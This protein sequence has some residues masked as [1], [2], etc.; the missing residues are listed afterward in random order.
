MKFLFKEVCAIAVI[1]IVLVYVLASQVLIVAGDSVGIDPPSTS[2]LRIL[3][4]EEEL[5]ITSAY[6]SIATGAVRTVTYPVMLTNAGEV[7]E[8][9]ALGATAPA[10]WYVCFLTPEGIP[11]ESLYLERGESRQ[12]VVRLAPSLDAGAGEISFVISA[13]SD[14]IARTSLNLTAIISE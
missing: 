4:V 1:C 8:N 2:H 3:P 6:S 11:I 12:L 9:V 10:D 7:S 13:T 5:N 14:G